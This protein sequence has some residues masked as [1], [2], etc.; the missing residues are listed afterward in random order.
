[1]GLLDLF[2]SSVDLEIS[3]FL[4]HLLS[5]VGISTTS[6]TSRLIKKPKFLYLVKYIGLKFKHVKKC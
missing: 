4:L 1:M 2:H 6:R 3:S 5:L